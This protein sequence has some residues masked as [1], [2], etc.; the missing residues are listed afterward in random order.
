VS[1]LAGRDHWVFDLDGTLTVAAHDFDAIRAELGLP[2]GKPILESLAALPRR[3]ADELRRRLD[4]IELA[5]AC[6]A[7]AAVGAKALL[8]ALRAGGARVGI[9]TRNSQHNAL[10]TLR[11]C[12]LDAFFADADV[13]DREVVA[14]KPDPAGLRLLLMR[15]GGDAGRAVMVG[16]YLFD[17]QAGR[18]AGAAVVYVDPSGAFPWREHADVVVR[19]L[20]ELRER[21]LALHGARTTR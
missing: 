7:R 14:P 17:L 10:A 11:A 4:E 21:V 15:W 2:A 5:I 20:V 8:D 13:I 12:G 3:D 16:D 9:L 18:G 19:D 6:E 1:R